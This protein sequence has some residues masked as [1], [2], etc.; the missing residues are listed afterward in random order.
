MISQT[1]IDESF[2]VGNFLL[3]EY[4]VPYRLDCDLKGGGILLYVREDILS[5]LLVIEEKE[6]GDFLCQVKFTQKQLACKLFLYSL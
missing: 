1:N 3:P 2:P 6:I 4:S 5:N